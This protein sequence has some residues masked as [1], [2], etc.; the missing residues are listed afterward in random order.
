MT[1]WAYFDESGHTD[2]P[3]VHAVA[4]A[5]AI[6]TTRA[7]TDLER[8][9]RRVLSEFGATEFHMKYLSAFRGEY[10]GWSENRRRDFLGQLMALMNRH[11]EQYIGAAMPLAGNWRGHS[12]EEMRERLRDPYVGCFFGCLRNIAKHV[13]GLPGRPHVNVVVAKN[14]EFSGWAGNVFMEFQDSQPGGDRMKTLVLGSPTEF[15]ALQV[16]DFV[17]YE[18]RRWAFDR[19]RGVPMRWPMQQMKHKAIETITTLQRKLFLD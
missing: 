7:W 17:A 16:S 1:L 11:V 3:N 14:P 4:V 19:D 5:G 2:D 6:A 15:P 13:A 9:W 10:S 8:E 12:D 18:V